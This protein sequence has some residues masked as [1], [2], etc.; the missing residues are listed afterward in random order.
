MKGLKSIIMIK[1]FSVYHFT[2]IHYFR[3]YI[4]MMINLHT[5]NYF[6]VHVFYYKY[7]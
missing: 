7:I 1:K 4:F 5:N 6:Y 2:P 3:I